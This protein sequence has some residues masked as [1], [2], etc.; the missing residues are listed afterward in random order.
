MVVSR[1]LS[2]LGRGG[3]YLGVGGVEHLHLFFEI[4]SFDLADEV[5]FHAG[6]GIRI[7]I[8]VLTPEGFEKGVD[9]RC[10][11]LVGG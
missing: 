7:P 6:W 3:A 4:H 10:S 1:G 11:R 9:G 8:G 5:L 2:W